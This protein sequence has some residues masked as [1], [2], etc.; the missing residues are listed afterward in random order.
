MW[1]NF[2]DFF[3]DSMRAYPWPRRAVFLAL[4][5][6]LAYYGFNW[7]WIAIAVAAFGLCEFDIWLRKQRKPR[8]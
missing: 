6:T 8:A 2:W 7:T 5:A 4:V 3:W 1:E